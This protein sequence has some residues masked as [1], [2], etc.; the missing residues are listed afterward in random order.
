MSETT[1]WEI[2]D[3]LELNAR[4]VLGAP[5]NALARAELRRSSDRAMAFRKI[6]AARRLL[7]QAAPPGSPGD[8][9][10][11]PPAVDEA[12]APGPG[13]EPSPDEP[14]TMPPGYRPPFKD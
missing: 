6:E 9:R 14:L 5:R 11:N 7:A 3:D 4:H 12:D 13:P 2:L 8:P 10:P 1:L